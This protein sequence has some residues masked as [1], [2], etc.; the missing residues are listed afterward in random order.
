[1]NR[2]VNHCSIQYKTKEFALSN[3][4]NTL[5]ISVKSYGSSVKCGTIILNL[6]DKICANKCMYV[7]TIIIHNSSTIFR[8]L[9]QLSHTCKSIWAISKFN[10]QFFHVWFVS[11]ALS[12]L[13]R[14]KHL[15]LNILI[16][17]NQNECVLLKSSKEI[18]PCN[19]AFLL[20][21]SN[22]YFVKHDNSTRR[23]FCYG[24]S[25]SSFKF[26][27]IWNYSKST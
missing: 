22:T 16:K 13:L 14:Q 1:M 12:L 26:K 6:P 20:S 7:Y 4:D 25:S 17:A 15:C 9:L 19:L 3:G 27:N 23:L 5:G 8:L 21:S 24:K 10:L 11:I 2:N 18:H